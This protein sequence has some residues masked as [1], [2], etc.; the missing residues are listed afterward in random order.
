VAFAETAT[1][2]GPW[3]SAGP[4]TLR[5]LDG[6]VY[7]G[8]TAPFSTNHQAGWWQRIPALHMSFVDGSVRAFSY[9]LAPS[10]FEALVTVAGSDQVPAFE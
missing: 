2:N 6:T 3:M 8:P 4:A 1:D 7:L 5:G 10:V 9:T